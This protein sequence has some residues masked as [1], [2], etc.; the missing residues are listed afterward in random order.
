VNFSD[1]LLSVIHFYPSCPSANPL[2]ALFNDHCTST[3]V[4]LLL[5]R[6]DPPRTTSTSTRVS[7]G[8][9]AASGAAPACLWARALMLRS[10]FRS[11]VS[12]LREEFYALSCKGFVV[13]LRS[14][15]PR[16]GW[17]PAR[18]GGE[19][20]SASEHAHRSVGE[21]PV[22]GP[23][24]A[25]PSACTRVYLRETCDVMV[26]TGLKRRAKWGFNLTVS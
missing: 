20:L 9:R 21:R 6:S 17:R 5:R 11:G 7:L 12:V 24:A 25:L 16:P 4:V 18:G 22:F 3:A 8:V 19:S 10:D 2:P 15:S 13:S 1:F 26:G 14:G 23:S